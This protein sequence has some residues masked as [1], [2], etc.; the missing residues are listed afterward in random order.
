MTYGDPYDECGAARKAER[1]QAKAL[2]CSMIDRINE[3]LKRPYD[4]KPRCHHGES[5]W[6]T[7]VSYLRGMSKGLQLAIEE[8]DGEDSLGPYLA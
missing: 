7:G 1:E 8:I 3:R 6:T 2:L 5:D 4:T